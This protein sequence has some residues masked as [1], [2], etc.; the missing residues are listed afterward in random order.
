MNISINCKVSLSKK[1]RAILGKEATLTLVSQD[2]VDG[3][4]TAILSLDSENTTEQIDVTGIGETSIM[5]TPMEIA[6]ESPNNE[7][8]MHSSIFSTIPLKHQSEKLIEKIAVVHAPERGQESTAIKKEVEVPK[9]FSQLKSNECKSWIKN[10]EELVGALNKA[11]NKKSTIDVTSARN[12]REK[13]ILQE[14]KEKEESIDESAWIINDKVGNLSINDLNISLQLNCPYDLSNIS[15]HKLYNSKDLKV[16]DRE[17]YIKFISPE[18]KDNIILNA[19]ESEDRN[20]G[21]DV[22]DDHESAMDAIESV[23]Q[24]KRRNTVINERN[25]MDVT[26]DNMNDATEEEEMIINLTQSAPLTKKIANGEVKKTTHGNSA[27]IER[28]PIQTD[29]TPKVHKT[30][31]RTG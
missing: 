27:Q 3:K 29:R 10:M 28:K 31:R 21:L 6:Y 18:E 1:L 30:A 11:K 12:E 26:E 2:I 4:G 23:Q 13:L 24:P 9:Q 5:L 17:G 16:L 22:F 7:S 14:R 15:A 8:L 25:A 20:I 19:E